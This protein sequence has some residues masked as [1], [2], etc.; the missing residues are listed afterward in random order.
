M[1]SIDGIP[2]RTTEN[3]GDEESGKT[4]VFGESVHHEVWHQLVV[5]LNYAQSYRITVMVFGVYD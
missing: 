2:E 1:D 3:T 5:S 4:R